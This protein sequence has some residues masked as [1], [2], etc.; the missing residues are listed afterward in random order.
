VGGLGCVVA[1]TIYTLVSKCKNGKQ[2]K[3]KNPKPN[4]TKTS[5]NQNPKLKI[6]ND[7]T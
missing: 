2:N 7:Q 6:K 5:K 4:Q 3:T 1:Q